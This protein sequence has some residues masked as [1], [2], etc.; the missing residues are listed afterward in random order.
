M[1]YDVLYELVV[2][3]LY[4]LKNFFLVTHNILKIKIIF[5]ICP[6]RR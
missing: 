2:W 6:T 5:I 3:L 4:N 1:V